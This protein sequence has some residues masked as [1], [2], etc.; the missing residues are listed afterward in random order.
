[1]DR[2]VSKKMIRPVMVRL[3]AGR[4]TYMGE[5]KSFET[6][7][8]G[9]EY[10]VGEGLRA[11]LAP[12]SMLTGKLKIELGLYTN[13]AVQRLDTAITGYWQMPTIPSPLQKMTAEVREL[14][15]KDIVYEVHT[16]VK[17]IS[18]IV[19]SE[20]TRSAVSNARRTGRNR[21]TGRPDQQPD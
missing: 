20:A 8:E 15:L 3:E 10:L 19:S 13:T 5:G 18:D 21:A 6:M 1:M 7:E 9:L 2:A 17:G 16:A 4:L 14:P 12:Q 11:Q